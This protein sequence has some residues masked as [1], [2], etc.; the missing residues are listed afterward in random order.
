[1]SLEIAVK[2]KSERI[3]VVFTVLGCSMHGLHLIKYTN[4]TNAKRK[5]A[6]TLKS[7]TSSL[8]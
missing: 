7:K 6:V 1:M 4:K 3:V 2:Y 8:I 5:G